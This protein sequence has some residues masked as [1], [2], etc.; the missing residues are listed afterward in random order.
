MLSGFRLAALA[1]RELLEAIEFYE[2]RSTGKGLTFAR[3]VYATIARAMELPG[4][5]TPV[6]DRRL[7]REV[8]YYRLNPEFPYNI[9]AAVVEIDVLFVFAVVHQRRRPGYWLGRTKDEGL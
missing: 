5:G 7:T 3:E 1:E 8:R 6:H 4:S 2:S 9:V